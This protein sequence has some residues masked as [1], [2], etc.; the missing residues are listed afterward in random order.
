M[1]DKSND[2]K[3]KRFPLGIVCAVCGVIALAIVAIAIVY[4]D[5]DPVSIALYGLGGYMVCVLAVGIA[6]LVRGTMGGKVMSEVRSSV[7]GNISLDFIQKL[8]MPV[9]ICDEKG[10]IVWYNTALSSRFRSRTM[11]FGKYIDNIC[12]ATIE[13][14]LKDDDEDGTEVSFSSEIDAGS[15]GECFRAKGYKVSSHGKTYYMAIFADY[16]ETRALAKKLDDEDTIVAYAMIDNLDE[17]MQYVQELYDTAASDV[18][19]ILR[20]HMEAVGGIVREY[21]NNKFICV[22]AAK[23]LEKFEEDKFSVLDEVREI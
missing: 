16:T 17:L 12:D 8:Y 7:F 2:T 21:A 1:S 5:G 3:K 23:Y 10:K 6:E 4:S 11:V 15:S 9:V 13:R 14:I 19:T 22:F 18:E 20:K